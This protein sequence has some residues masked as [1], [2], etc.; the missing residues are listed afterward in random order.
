MLV[1]PNFHQS[2]QRIEKELEWIARAKDDP[3]AFGPLYKTYYEMIFRYVYQR[4]DDRE[5]CNDVVSQ[6]FVKAMQHLHRYEYRGLPFSSWLFRIAKSEVHQYFRDNKAERVV[7]VESLQLFE[8]MGELDEDESEI[9]KRKLMR[10]LGQLKENDLQMLEMRFF[11]GRSFKEIGEILEI[12]ETNA[13]VRSFRAL[14][15]LKTL[16]NKK[17]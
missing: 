9:N 13:K 14:E 2:Q 10:A 3:S 8:V 12:T 16:F 7:N 17:E 11:E 4:M 5:A 1:N 6:I 15:R